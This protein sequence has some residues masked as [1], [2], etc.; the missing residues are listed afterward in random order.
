LPELSLQT[1]LLFPSSTREENMIRYVTLAAAVVLSLGCMTPVFAQE[2]PSEGK[3]SITYTAVNPAPSKAVSVGDRDVTVSSSI[4]TG[5]N[6]AGSGLLHNMAGRCNFMAETNKVAKTIHTRG[7]CSYAD[8]AGDQVFEEFATDGPVTLGSPILFKGTWLGGTGKFEGLSGE[9]E[10]RP[11]SVL[12]SD[13]LVQ[14][15][16]KKTGTYQIKKSPVAQK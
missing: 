12:V 10:I 16:G 7:F 9:F 3:F 11:V 8:R 13:T 1:E 4:M 5:V 6:D 15:A 2:L 14:G